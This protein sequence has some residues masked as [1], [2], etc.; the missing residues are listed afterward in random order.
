MFGKKIIISLLIFFLGGL[1]VVMAGGPEEA[2]PPEEKGEVA[3][4]AIM[5]Q[6][7]VWGG[8]LREMIPDFELLDM[9]LFEIID[10]ILS[11]KSSELL[12]SIWIPKSLL[13]KTLSITLI[14]ESSK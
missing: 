2:A 8:G 5:M 12:E 9:I 1:S 7:G 11:P 6:G 3:V 13:I 14:S 4:R 10:F